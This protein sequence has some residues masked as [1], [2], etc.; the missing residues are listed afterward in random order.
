MRLMLSLILCCASLSIAAQE[1]WG[2]PVN[3]FGDG[4]PD[5][6]IEDDREQLLGGSGAGISLAD[7]RVDAGTVSCDGENRGTAMVIE[8]GEF[9][10]GL[11][12]V[13]LVSAAHVFYDLEKKRLFK[14]CEFHY[15]GLGEI[16]GYRAMIDLSVVLMGDYDPGMATEEMGFGEGDW[17]FLY[18]PVPWRNFNPGEGTRLLDFHSL[19]LEAFQQSRG[20]FRL[21]AFDSSR[22]VM[23]VSR[24]C[25]VTESAV[26]DIGGGVWKGQLLDN[27]DS[28]DGASGGGI[29]AVF[30]GQRYLVGIRN[31]SHWSE[32]AYPLSQY[33]HGPPDGSTW[34]RH[35]NTNFA[36]GIDPGIIRSF[37]KFV[38]GIE[39]HENTI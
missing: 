33:P 25:T 22:S 3:I 16:P 6:G 4:N 26:S 17:A 7:Q 18:L 34:S 39:K 30:D 37:K 13:V 14:N 9:A 21:I 38:K 1:Q 8:T 35:T 24:H 2:V 29:I 23:S 12:G 19:E 27:C 28:A 10:V 20:E 15:M 36:R 31:G 5:N 11:N 32:E